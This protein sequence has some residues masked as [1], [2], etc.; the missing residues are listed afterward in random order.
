[1]KTPQDF[2]VLI[3]DDEELL[4]ESIIFDFKR[5]GFK[6]LSA[7]N[8]TVAFEIFQTNSV[9]LVLS[10]IRMPGGDG[11][12]LLKKIHARG[13]Q[14]PVVIFMTGFSE[15]APEDVTA[16]GV[17]KIITKPFERKELMSMIFEMLGLPFP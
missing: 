5:K 16:L 9:D 17:R 4:R 1:M 13:G 11:I 14:I 6:V 7:A 12:F 2:T 10:D 3:V 8:G 15:V